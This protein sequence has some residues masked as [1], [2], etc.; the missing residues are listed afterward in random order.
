M[1]Q[2]LGFL[3]LASSLLL[4]NLRSPIKKSVVTTA[5]PVWG[6]HSDVP[7]APARPA[8]VAPTQIDVENSPPNDSSA[9]AAPPRIFD[10]P[11]FPKVTRLVKR[12]LPN[13]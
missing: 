9:E 2:V 8:T 11:K 12:P 7:I 6:T 3:I 4:P 5:K 13:N 10:I 1:V